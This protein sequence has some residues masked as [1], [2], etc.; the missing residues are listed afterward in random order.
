M[1]AS[2]LLMRITSDIQLTVREQARR[3]REPSMQK[4][5]P[6]SS[7]WS[8]WFTGMPYGKLFR[9]LKPYSLRALN[10][11]AVAVGAALRLD[12]DDAVGRRRAVDRRAGGALH[13]FDRLDVETA[14]A[15]RSCRR[16]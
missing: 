1:S 2:T 12:H 6:V 16:S 14:Q 4:R 8:W 7:S 3:R 9:S 15:R 5:V 13:D 11:H 10:C